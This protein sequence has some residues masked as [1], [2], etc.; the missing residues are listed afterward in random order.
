MKRLSGCVVSGTLLK[1][2]KEGSDTKDNS[3]VKEEDYQSPIFHEI[4][5]YSDARDST[6]GIHYCLSMDDE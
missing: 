5:E 1:V 6:G 4:L 3:C 2:V